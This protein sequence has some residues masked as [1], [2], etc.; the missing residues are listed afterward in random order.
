MPYPGEV[1]R[2]LEVPVATSYCIPLLKA[3]LV[4]EEWKVAEVA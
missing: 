2:E 4:L 3:A 1:R